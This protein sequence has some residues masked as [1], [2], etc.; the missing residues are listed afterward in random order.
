MSPL[1]NFPDESGNIG[2]MGEEWFH[3]MIDKFRS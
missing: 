3:L 1:L 2:M